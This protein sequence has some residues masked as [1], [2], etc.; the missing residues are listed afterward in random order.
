MLLRYPLLLFT[1][2]SATLSA[3]HTLG[4]FDGHADIGNVKTA[5]SVIYNADEQSYTLTGSGA[6]IWFAQDEFHYLWKH[7]KGD[8][9]LQARASFTGTGG[10]PHRKLGWTVRNSL[11]GDSP[12]VSAAVHGDGLAA[13][14]AAINN[15]EQ[16]ARS[17][18][19]EHNSGAVSA[20]DRI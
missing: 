10:D 11:R 3:Q 2:F 9:I 14:T 19:R 5:G 12:H 17:W 7:L 15:D 1:M 8:F 6:N 13:L 4:Q 18:F 16:R 20:T